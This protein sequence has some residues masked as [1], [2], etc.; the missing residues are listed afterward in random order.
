M[1]PSIARW[2]MLGLAL[3]AAC[4]RPSDGRILVPTSGRV[5]LDGKV[6]E[7]ALV[8]FVPQSAG[9]IAASATTDAKGRYNLHTPGA[10]RP[11]VVPGSY[12]VTIM[13]IET[14]QLT[15]EEQAMSM[16]KMTSKGLSMPPPITESTQVLPQQYRNPE[17]SGFTASVSEQERK[18]FDF[19]VKSR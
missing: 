17:E 16:V 5:M 6:L 1:K 13:K 2:F 18:S 14:R 7:G 12:A 9:G 10:S 15:T 4:G 11:G 3:V 19:D 8:T